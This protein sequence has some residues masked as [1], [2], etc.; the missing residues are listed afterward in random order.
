MIDINYD[1]EDVPITNPFFFALFHVEI[2][3]SL[4]K[5]DIPRIP[6]DIV[7]MIS[8]IVVYLHDFGLITGVVRDSIERLLAGFIP[9]EIWEAIYRPGKSALTGASYL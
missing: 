3:G 1:W 6:R 5:E 7:E 8:E 4:N 9:V 2:E